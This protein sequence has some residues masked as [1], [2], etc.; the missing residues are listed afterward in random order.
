ME[1]ET[2][3][4]F[5]N[6]ALQNAIKYSGRAEVSSVIGKIL[7][8]KP[9]LK[10]EIGSIAKDIAEA[11]NSVNNMPLVEQI[12]EL[13]KIAPELLEVKT[14]KKEAGLPELPDAK[15]SVVMRLAPFPS[16][17]LHIGN[18]K[19]YL[20]NAFY[21]EKYNAKLLLVMDD[22]I[23]SKEKQIMPESYNLIEEAFAWLNVKYAKPVIYKS[24]RLEIYYSN[25]EKIIEKNKAYVCF[26]SAEKLRKD[27][28]EGNECE[29]RKRSIKENSEEWKKML[30]GSYKEGQAIL[31]IKT[32]MKD[33]NPAFR[34]RVLFRI[35][36]REHPR[37]GKKYSVWPMLE[38]SWAID[39]HLLGVTHII[40]GKDL[41]ME[42]EMC[43]FIWDIFGW[44]HPVM[45]HA[46]LIRIEG[47]EVKISK[48]KAQQEVKKGIFTGW[49]DPRTWSI[50]SLRRRGIL[51]ESIREFVKSIGLNENDIAVPVD[52]LY[53]INRKRIETSNRYFF[54]AEP[55][56]IKISAA[57]DSHPEV[58]LHPD[59]P[60]RGTRKFST[61]QEFYIAK[62]DYE[63]MQKS[64]GTWRFMH[65]FNFSGEELSY[66]STK[67]QPELGA[68]LI[69]WLPADKNNE[70]N[71]IKT[72]IQMPDGSILKG[73]AEPGIKQLKVN[74]E[75]QFERFGFCRLDSINADKTKAV[76]WFSHK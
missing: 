38:F 54:V 13:R 53:S 73:L 49:D 19:T 2:K 4:L 72:E 56:K 65:L 25:A 66:V 35:S 46:G 6:Y 43:K 51:A 15:G 28:E 42:S 23:G 70:K 3:S 76:F 8:E 27:R 44:K 67:M 60:E 32:S 47:L 36:N 74:D 7:Q 26:C 62:T 20:L 31:R 14:E 16:G 68:K 58:Q 10:K 22:T 18:A 52:V 39:D 17:A 55:E 11:V 24:D 50:Q 1:K 37:V 71:I 69:H 63:Q 9:E 48:S 30:K 5:R 34:D 40:R 45:I 41:M 61:M 75:I 57:P 12:A 29:C 33:K 59:H 21:A 64:K